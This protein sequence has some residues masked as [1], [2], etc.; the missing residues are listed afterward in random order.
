MNEEEKDERPEAGEGAAPQPAPQTEPEVEF[1]AD[2]GSRETPFPWLAAAICV[3]VLGVVAGF[4][5][6]VARILN[7]I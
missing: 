1:S 2:D 6:S 7:L 5:Y 4:L 3:W